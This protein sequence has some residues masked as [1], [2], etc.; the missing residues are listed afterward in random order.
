[1]A[2]NSSGLGLSRSGAAIV[3]I[4]LTPFYV[5]IKKGGSNGAGR[6]LVPRFLSQTMLQKG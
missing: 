5:P 1:M 2:G 3:R 4:R 6:L